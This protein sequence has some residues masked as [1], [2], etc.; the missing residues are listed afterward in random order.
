VSLPPSFIINLACHTILLPVHADCGVHLQA[1]LVAVK[2]T[3]RRTEDTLRD[4]QTQV[5][6]ARSCNFLLSSLAMLYY[7]CQASVNKLS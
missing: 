7:A 5:R 2:E 3:G 1:D 6:V 4:V